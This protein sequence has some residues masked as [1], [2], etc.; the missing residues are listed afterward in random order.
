MYKEKEITLHHLLTQLI[1]LMHR[2]HYIILNYSTYS[3]HI[4]TVIYSE[5]I[6]NMYSTLHIERLYYTIEIEIKQKICADCQLKSMH[7]FSSFI[8]RCALSMPL[9]TRTTHWL[10]APPSS[11]HHTRQVLTHN[12][13]QL[14]SMRICPN[15]RRRVAAAEALQ[16]PASSSSVRARCAFECVHR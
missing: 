8:S 13:D 1:R 14:D 11:T 9:R 3:T 2:N 15:R 4:Q 7:R 10:I 6:S 12:Y 5:Y 16:S